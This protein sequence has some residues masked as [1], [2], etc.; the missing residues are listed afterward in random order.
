MQAAQPVKPLRYSV[1]TAAKL[2][3]VTGQAVRELVRSGVLTGIEAKAHARGRKVYLDPAEV[4]A[5]A[6]GGLAGV[7]AYREKQ[8]RKRK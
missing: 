1:S 6:R 3:D 2:L 7:V 4:E 5:Y 8:S